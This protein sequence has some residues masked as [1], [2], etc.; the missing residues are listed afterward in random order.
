MIQQLILK[1]KPTS[2]KKIVDGDLDGRIRAN[3]RHKTR[4]S[5]VQESCSNIKAWI[6]SLIQKFKALVLEKDELELQDMSDLKAFLPLLAYR[7]SK[8]EIAILF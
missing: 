3:L 1:K 5:S 4:D 6:Q 8:S 7:D 2:E